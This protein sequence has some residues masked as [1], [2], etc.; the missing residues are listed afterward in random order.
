MYPAGTRPAPVAA[1]VNAEAAYI[2]F[3]L[4]ELG[5]VP[6]YALPPDAGFVDDVIYVGVDFFGTKKDDVVTWSFEDFSDPTNTDIVHISGGVTFGVYGF[7]VIAG[8]NLLGRIIC[9]VN[10][11]EYSVNVEVQN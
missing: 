5:E 2:G 10:G 9:T 4:N 3:S 8:V 1:A 7:H 11:T 6:L